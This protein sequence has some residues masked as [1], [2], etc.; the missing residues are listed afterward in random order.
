[1]KARPSFLACKREEEMHQELAPVLSRVLSLLDKA[2]AY[3][4]FELDSNSR[5]DGSYL[6]VEL[7]C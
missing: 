2:H 4:E 6:L 5:L 7:V 3:L 1:M